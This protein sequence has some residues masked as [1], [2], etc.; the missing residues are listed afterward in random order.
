M[1]KNNGIDKS[2]LK[3]IAKLIVIPIMS[4]AAMSEGLG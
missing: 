2:K 4:Q 1:S 3:V